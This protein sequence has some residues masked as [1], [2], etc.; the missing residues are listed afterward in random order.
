MGPGKLVA[1]GNARTLYLFCRGSGAPTVILETGFSGT[2]D[3]WSAVQPAVARRTRTCAYDRA[4]LGD[5]PPI[6][7]VHDASQ[8]IADLWRLLGHAAIRPPYIVVGAS[9]G[10]LLARLFAH[11]HPRQ[12]RGIVL[13]DAM[14]HNQDRRLLP[15]WRAQSAAVR[16]QVPK[17]LTPAHPV[18]SGVNLL[19]GEDLDARVR[20][21]GDTP[22]IVI[23]RGRIEDLGIPSPLPGPIRRPVAQIWQTMQNELAG[24]SP[25]SIHV[26][27]LRSGHSIQSF[28]DGQ[29]DVV[30]AAVLAVIRAAR[31]HT[32]LP[33][34]PRVFHDSGT[35]CRT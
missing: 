27:A 8:E 21:L 10:G 16:S 29:P 33:R 31:T 19:A 9:Y 25:D 22:L 34:C 32:H 28:A 6:P 26:V 5:S 2:S 35:Q 3:D 23:T 4:G 1:I 7:G 12:V 13:V 11:A 17:P 14:G 20:S 30:I 18:D 15:V 24:L